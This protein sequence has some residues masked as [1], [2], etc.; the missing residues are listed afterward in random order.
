MSLL[1]LIAAIET[2]RIYFKV[3]N[4]FADLMSFK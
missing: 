2:V 4:R 3:Q 1:D